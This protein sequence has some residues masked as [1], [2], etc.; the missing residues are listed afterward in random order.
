MNEK[1]EVWVKC[2][3]C[4]KGFDNYPALI[5]HLEGHIEKKAFGKRYLWFYTVKSSNNLANL[6]IELI[7]EA[8]LNKELIIEVYGD[9]ER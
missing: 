2:N 6:I 9:R 4:G 3:I 7:I 8:S 5:A 1:E